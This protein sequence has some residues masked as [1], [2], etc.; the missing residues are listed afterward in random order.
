VK[1]DGRINDDPSHF[2]QHIDNMKRS[3]GNFGITFHGDLE[4]G[5][6]HI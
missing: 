4:H 2:G 5:F 3:Q 1:Q 6:L